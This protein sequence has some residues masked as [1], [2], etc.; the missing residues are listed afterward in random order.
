M[1]QRGGCL[2]LTH[3]FKVERPDRIE[4]LTLPSASLI[5]GVQRANKLCGLLHHAHCLQAVDSRGKPHCFRIDGLMGPH[6]DFRKWL[7]W[8]SKLASA[9]AA[10]SSQTSAGRDLSPFSPRT[11][12]SEVQR[13]GKRRQDHRCGYEGAQ[14]SWE[15]CWHAYRSVARERSSYGRRQISPSIPGFAA[16]DTGLNQSRGFATDSDL[17]PPLHAAQLA[18]A[19]AGGRDRYV[20]PRPSGRD[21][22]VTPRLGERGDR[23]VTPRPGARDQ[24]V[25][26]RLGGRDRYVTPR[27]AGRDEC[28]SRR[29][30]RWTRCAR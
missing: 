5:D 3:S 7:P 29:G 18:R 30:R 21:R 2:P 28:V 17:E 15:T 16:A 6:R 11:G 20:T 23:C 25:T 24:H 10:I 19:P 22:C 8:A 27:L 4:T 14:P 26:P 12:V 9:T 13:A 1:A